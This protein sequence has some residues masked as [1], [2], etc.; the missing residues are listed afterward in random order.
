MKDKNREHY[1]TPG[2]AAL[3][4][5]MA[6]LMQARGRPFR[7]IVGNKDLAEAVGVSTRMVQLYVASSVRKGF[8]IVDRRRS[9]HTNCYELPKGFAVPTGPFSTAVPTQVLN[10]M[11][12][13][14]ASGNF[15]KYIRN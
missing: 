2:E 1:A 6:T 7:L 14:G 3:L 11:V 9:P 10:K 12:R 15:E 8:L 13:N 5:Y 4:M